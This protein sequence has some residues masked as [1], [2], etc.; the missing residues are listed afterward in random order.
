MK[1]LI[2]ILIIALGFGFLSSCSSTGSMMSNS[3]GYGYSDNVYYHGYPSY[4]GAYPYLN[5]RPIIR[6]NIIVV[7]DQKRVR[8]RDHVRRRESISPNNRRRVVP[9]ESNRSIIRGN[10][11]R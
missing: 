3:D 6:N 9:S 2:N 8:N 1:R 7:P 4:Y 11:E 10:N 5:Q